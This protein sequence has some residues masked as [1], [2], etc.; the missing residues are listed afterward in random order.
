MEFPTEKSPPERLSKEQ[1]MKALKCSQQPS[2]WTQRI[3]ERVL[4]NIGDDSELY[5]KNVS[6]PIV[7]SVQI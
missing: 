7:T 5:R 6:I 2:D 4:S 3:N 1:D